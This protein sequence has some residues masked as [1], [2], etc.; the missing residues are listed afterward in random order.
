MNHR[1]EQLLNTRKTE[2][3]RVNGTVHAYMPVEVRTWSP[4][5]VLAISDEAEALAKFILSSNSPDGLTLLQRSGNQQI[6]AGFSVQQALFEL[7]DHI[8]PN[9]KPVHT[10][11]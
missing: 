6:M 1:N 5:E 11:R 10:L 9:L 8:N 3:Q 4:A 2:A 7:Y